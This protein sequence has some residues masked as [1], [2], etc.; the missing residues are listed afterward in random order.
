MAAVVFKNCINKPLKGFA[1]LRNKFF[2]H[3][4]PFL[5]NSNLKRTKIWMGNCIC[6][7]F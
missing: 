4:I 5:F 2:G 7:V 1:C 3:F 6:F